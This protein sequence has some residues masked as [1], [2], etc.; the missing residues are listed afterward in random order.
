[1][2][3]V[4]VILQGTVSDYT[5]C[6][7]AVKKACAF[8][9]ENEPGTLVYECFADE[10]SGRLLWHE[11][12]ADADAFI[13]HMQNMNETGI[14]GEMMAAVTPDQVTSLIP[15]EDPRVVQALEQFGI[16]PLRGVGG[17]VRPVEKLA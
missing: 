9:E 14:I 6:M 10:V 8:V 4:R 11:T 16:L 2:S 5:S 15:S 13:T 7:T 12:Y 17:F 1:M 3:Q